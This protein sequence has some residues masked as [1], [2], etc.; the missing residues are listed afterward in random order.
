MVYITKNEREQQ[1]RLWF[2]KNLTNV[3][4]VT[5]MFMIMFG[6]VILRKVVHYLVS[7]KMLPLIKHQNF[8]GIAVVVSQLDD[9]KQKMYRLFCYLIILNHSIISMLGG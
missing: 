1:Y 7:S 8:T 2:S 3:I 6:K 9:I 4:V 5:N